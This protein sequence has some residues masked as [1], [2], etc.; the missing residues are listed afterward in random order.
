MVSKRLKQLQQHINN[1]PG[2]VSLNG[3]GV[4]TVVTP[5]PSLPP[6]TYPTPPP[7]KDA[8][9]H[10]EVVNTLTGTV[11]YPTTDIIIKNP[12]GGPD[13]D[14]T[15]TYYSCN[16]GDR[17]NYSPGLTVGWFHNYDI[18]FDTSKLATDSQV[19]L[20]HPNLGTEQ[21]APPDILTT[22]DKNSFTGIPDEAPYFI[23]GAYDGANWTS[24]T[25]HWRNLDTW[26][27]TPVDD[28]ATKYKLDTITCGRSKQ[29]L[30]FSWE[31]R[32]LTAIT[33]YTSSGLPTPMAEFE[34]APDEH[35]SGTQILKRVT[36]LVTCH[37]V[38]YTHEDID[39]SSMLYVPWLSGVSQ[40]STD[41]EFVLRE[42]YTYT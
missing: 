7:W 14:F 12:I 40:P 13:V 28:D 38:D 16:T 25:M 29:R 11:E 24:F 23:T 9:P 32:L 34:Y 15:R 17:D 39:I 33:A 42:G 21:L 4:R 5:P 10:D 1:I 26:L 30:V 19:I 18:Y 37:S 8:H 31:S 3:A 35:N 27:F 41:Y 2:R 20:Y 36:D 22:D 6:D